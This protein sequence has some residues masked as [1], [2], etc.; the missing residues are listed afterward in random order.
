MKRLLCLSLLCIGSLSC[1]EDKVD[2]FVAGEI[3]GKVVTRGDNEPVE[4]VKVST[5]PTSSTVF[6]NADGNFILEEVP[7]GDYSVKAEK[8][9]LLTTFEA[10]T[11]REGAT[12]SI[13]F[14]M[15]VET[16]ANRPPGA[17][18][19]LLPEDVA[20]DIGLE[21]LFVWSASDPDEEDELV[22]SL[23]IKND[24]DDQVFLAENIT[25]TVYRVSGLSF[26]TKYFW[27]VTASDSINSPV[28]SKVSSFTT[29]QNPENRFHY[30]REE[31]GNN[32]I[33]SSDSLQ[34]R[35]FT[36]TSNT[37]N[38]F[39]PKKNNE[40][41]RIAYLKTVGVETHLFT[42]DLSGDNEFQVT[43]SVS[44]AGFDMNEVEFDW[45]S[46]G[47]HFIYPNFN[48]LYRISLDGSGLQTLY[49]T[50]D[51][52]FITKCEWSEDGSFIAVTTNDQNGYNASLHLIDRSGNV[53]R[54]IV[55]GVQGALGGVSISVD[56]RK[57]LYT[58][59]VSG[60]ENN[61]YRRL[62]ARIF[63]YDL[64]T[65]ITIDLSQDKAAG[66]NDL[67]PMFSPD[68]AEVIFVNTSNDGISPKSVFRKPVTAQ[69]ERSLL[70]N[71]AFM[72]DWQ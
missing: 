37:R 2:T 51:G 28:L 46:N 7:S 24:R 32:I 65:D 38:S 14:E 30:V 33:I 6:S 27:Q 23:E 1:N 49:E 43:S 55:S 13:V 69:G 40:V 11:I 20:T 44:V 45:S 63:L 4:N 25:D 19:L 21:Y 16:A 34:Q 8:E 53:L 18:Q 64:D 56:G 60:F 10:V 41:R 62:D 26:G 52:S 66:T 50:T 17:P 5:E 48:R 61:A 68:N 35:A 42:M 15:D 47:A 59:D 9:G 36:M 22:Y 71:N 3:M 72:P 70:F 29:L 39:R 12:V 58:R 57:I 54:T 67:D 31:N